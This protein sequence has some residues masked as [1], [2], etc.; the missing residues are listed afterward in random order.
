MLHYL[1][2]VVFLLTVLDRTTGSW[3][4]GNMNTWSQKSHYCGG[5]SQSPID[6]QFNLSQ[7]DRRLKPIHLAAQPNRGEQCRSPYARVSHCHCQVRLKWSTMVIQVGSHVRRQPQADWC[8][9]LAAQINMKNHL[10][11]KHV[12]PISEDY[13]VEQIHFHWGDADD[14]INGSEHLLEGRSYPLEV[15]LTRRIVQTTSLAP[16]F[17]CISSRT[18]VCSKTSVKRCRPRVA[19]LSLVSSSK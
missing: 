7:Y 17:R 2:T 18:R 4:Y 10:R 19:W 16:S 6:L 15:T 11:L 13:V 8:I 14:T 5:K 3:S 12:T 1:L 9:S